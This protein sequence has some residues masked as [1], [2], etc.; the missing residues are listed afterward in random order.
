MSDEQLIDT[1][2]R[3]SLSLTPGDLDHTLGQITAAAV[4]VLPGVTYASITMLRADGTLDTVAPTESLILVLD[5]AQYRLRQG[6]CYEAATDSIHVASANLAA[7]PRFPDYGAIAVA[8]G[9]KAQAG[10][11]LFDT[12]KARGALNLYSPNVGAFDDLE[13]LSKLFAHQAG[14][15]ISY[16][17]EIQTL[18][19]SIDTRAMIGQAIGILMERYKLDDQRAFAFLARLS[20]QRNIK[21]RKLAEEVNA[22]VDP[23]EG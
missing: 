15:V 20:Q 13:I 1:A 7:D 19:E 12:G 21:L 8:A 5:A 9:I 18:R 16:S 14:G 2:R 11:R 22:T 6:P 17:N 4:E 23:A 3:L 10:V